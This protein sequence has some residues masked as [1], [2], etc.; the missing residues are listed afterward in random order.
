VAD[1]VFYS[2][3]RTIA[4][5]IHPYIWEALS[6]SA[7]GEQFEKAAVTDCSIWRNST[8][9]ATIGHD[10]RTSAVHARAQP[11]R[12]TNACTPPFLDAS[13]LIAA[14]FVPTSETGVMELSAV[15]TVV[16]ADSYRC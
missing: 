9:H 8:K 15:Y 7:D 2:G 5:H 11:I 13:R 6:S 12:M 14:R 4:I 16:P 3:C 1:L 10:R